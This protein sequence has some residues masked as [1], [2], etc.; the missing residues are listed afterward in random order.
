MNLCI[1]SE[2]RSA[3]HP[4]SFIKAHKDLLGDNVHFLYG[5]TLPQYSEKY[6]SLAKYPSLIGRIQLKLGFSKPESPLIIG[7]RNYLLQEQIDVV[8]AEYG[9]TGAQVFPI[10]KELDIPLVVHFHGYDISKKEV[11]EYYRDLYPQ[12]FAYASGIVAVSK[13]MQQDLIAA[14]APIEKVHL[15][16]CGPQE[17]FFSIQPDYTSNLILAV[18]RMTDKKAPYYTIMAFKETLK[19]FPDLRLLMIGSGYLENAMKNLVRALDLQDRIDIKG[20]VHHSEIE[21]YY[22]KAFC[23]VQ[24]SIVAEDGDSEGTPVG[25]L[26]SAAAALPVISTRHKGIK[27]AVIDGE[28]GF[29]VDEHDIQLMAEKMSKLA[30]NRDVVKNFGESARI[31]ICKNYHLNHQIAQLHALIINALK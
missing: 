3:E 28:T 21:E 5:G 13:D 2:S 12:L 16:P 14:G 4:E 10:C 1:I 22:K 31:H 30:S 29:L 7:L 24:H 23:F 6:G 27:D 8:L 9:T 11:L 17:K 15:I 26:E 19:Q 25:I 20:W 18:G